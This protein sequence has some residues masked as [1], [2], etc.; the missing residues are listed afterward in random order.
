MTKCSMKIYKL[1]KQIIHSALARMI[2][3]TLVSAGATIGV[4]ALLKLIPGAEGDVFRVIRWIISI[5][6]LFSTYFYFFRYY[7]KRE[8][9]ELAAQKLLPEGLVGFLSSFLLI[10]L[11]VLIL[12]ISGH[13][14]IQSTGKFSVLVM[15]L[16]FFTVA[17]AVEEVVFRGI[18]YRILE[19]SWGTNFALVLSAL[20]FGT[21]HLANSHAN[22][23]SVISVSSLGLLLGLLYSYKQRLWLPLGFH[24][25]WNWTMSG[26][27]LVVSGADELPNFIEARLEGPELVTGGGFGLENSLITI[28]FII[29]LSGLLYYLLIMKSR[30]IQR[31]LSEDE[32]KY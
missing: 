14:S 3:G 17:A 6:V 24:I 13:Y 22:W 16:F 28:S 8:I 18:F 10:G 11:I 25:G 19:E 26:L 20:V 4:N 23:M 31:D 5:A 30:T 27:G 1:F 32:N 2:I 21:I 7:E 9:S 12:Y 15:S 29:I